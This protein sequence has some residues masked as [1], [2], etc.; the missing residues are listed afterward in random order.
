MLT[1]LST[2]E[3]QSELAKLPGWSLDG[4][5]L[6]KEFNFVDFRIAFGFISTIALSC[7]SM[8]HHPEWFNVYNKVRIWLTSHEVNG[9]S[10]NDVLLAQEI[11]T[12]ARYHPKAPGT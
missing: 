10:R 4:G 9:I 2:M 12:V 8:N 6:H 3:I 7:E 1:K 11:E 5:K